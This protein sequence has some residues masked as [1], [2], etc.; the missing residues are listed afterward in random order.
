MSLIR[1]R[2][3]V[4]VPDTVAPE[5]LAGYIRDVESDGKG[6]VILSIKLPLERLG[7]NRR[8]TVSKSVAVKFS[9]VA[10]CQPSHLTAISWRPAGG[11]PFPHFNG[12]IGILPN[13][14]DDSCDL[15]LQGEYDPP[16]GAIGDA[17]DAVVGKH[18]ARLTARNLLDEIAI[19][20]E[21]VHAS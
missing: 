13:G 9:E 5:Y 16:L 2:R 3:F 17:F 6:H 21:S 11:G 12:T 10:N 15:T 14:T 1:E 20:M 19:M 4:Q 18:I 7:F 8:L